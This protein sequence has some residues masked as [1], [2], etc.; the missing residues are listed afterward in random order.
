MTD[1]IDLK[2]RATQRQSVGSTYLHDA[3]IMHQALNLDGRPTQ[4]KNDHRP[5]RR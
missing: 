3:G 5:R 4:T 2:V 1:L